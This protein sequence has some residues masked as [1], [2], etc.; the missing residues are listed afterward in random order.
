MLAW[1]DKHH[2]EHLREIKEKKDIGNKLETGMKDALKAFN[3]EFAAN[4]PPA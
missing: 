2:Q 4:H 1:L 3:K